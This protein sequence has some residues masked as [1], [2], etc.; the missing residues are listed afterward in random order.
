PGGFTAS[1]AGNLS[2]KVVF[3]AGALKITRTADAGPATRTRLSAAHF[4]AVSDPA[5]DTLIKDGLLEL[6]PARFR[7]LQLDVDGAGLKAMNF[8]RSLHR[9]F[10]ADA[11]VDPVTRQEDEI[12]ASALRTAGLMLVQTS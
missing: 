1:N 9:R 2:V 6:S 5:A 11:R 8:A 7:V 12:G 3:P 10:D 4:D